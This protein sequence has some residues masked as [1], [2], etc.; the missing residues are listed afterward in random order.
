MRPARWACCVLLLVACASS[1]PVES[2]NAHVGRELDFAF[3]ALDGSVVTSENSRGRTTAL[4]FVTT[5]DLP[6]HVAVR[7]LDDLLR[8][9]KPRFN[10][11]VVVLENPENA[12]LVQAFRDT[13]R[14]SCPVAI[15]DLTE[16]RSHP[17][18]RSI[19]RVPLLV[20]VDRRGRERLR[21]AGA[22]E[23]DELGE[24]LRAAEE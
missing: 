7:R 19:D 23:P 3:G 10:A 22:F 20:L 17:G 2:P 14:V 1:E 11:A 21:H 9:R 8:R 6:S 16:L 5:Y 18:F 15:A 4:L 13:L 24:W 12:V